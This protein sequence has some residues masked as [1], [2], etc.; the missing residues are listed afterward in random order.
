M[1][2]T[3]ITETQDDYL[4]YEMA[5]AADV[6]V[7]DVLAVAPGDQVLITADTRS[8][9]RVTDATAKA[10]ATARGVPMVLRYGS[11]GGYSGAP[12][13]AVAA[14]AAACDIWI[15]YATGHLI[16]T[17]AWR[18][19]THAGV[20]YVS[21]GGIDVDGFVRCIGQQDAASLSRIG[22]LVIERLRGAVVHMTTPAGSDIRFDN[23]GADVGSFAMLAN[24][25]RRAIMLAGQVTWSLANEESM[26]GTLVA[27]GILAPPDEIGL[28]ANPVRLTVRGGRIAEIEG[29]REATALT[30]WLEHRD[31]PVLRRTAHLSLGFN[32]GISAP[33]G[34][35]LEDERAF[36]DLDFGFGAWTDRVA[37]GHF[38]FTCRQVSMTCDGRPLLVDGCFADPEI[39]SICDQLGIPGHGSVA[40][41]S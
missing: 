33:S 29:G 34:R 40:R 17:D 23:T 10:V 25:E 37:A 39:R 26:T 13:R 35:I 14:A 2:L 4:S 21:L 32:P 1:R 7:R 5:A 38:D 15:E 24:P 31:D 6:L 11:G 28:L 18:A 20:Q 3:Y 41:S 9:G 22:D 30:R 8:D 12:P 27:D 16:Y 36:G 19:A